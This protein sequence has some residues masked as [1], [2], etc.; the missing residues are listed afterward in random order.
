MQ[1]ANELW[2]INNSNVS[3][4]GSYKAMDPMT[5]FNQQ[6]GLITCN[7]VSSHL[8]RAHG[9]NRRKRPVRCL[10]DDECNC[11]EKIQ[12]WELPPTTAEMLCAECVT[13]DDSLE[14][15]LFVTT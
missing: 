2:K 10:V 7:V 6:L 11:P 8:I 15:G 5:W 14:S 12:H 9:K 13:H 1:R 3:Y 4:T